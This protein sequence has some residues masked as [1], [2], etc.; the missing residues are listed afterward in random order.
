L[1]RQA[2]ASGHVAA[3]CG[4]AHPADRARLGWDSRGDGSLS[5]PWRRP[6]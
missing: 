4:A 5:T 6:A 1:G 3:G 2:S